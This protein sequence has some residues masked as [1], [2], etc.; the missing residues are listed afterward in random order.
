MENVIMAST[1]FLRCIQVCVFCENYPWIMILQ[2]NVSYLP[3]D[4][5][6]HPRTD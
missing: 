1:V 3:S 5:A 2:D 6:P 4:T